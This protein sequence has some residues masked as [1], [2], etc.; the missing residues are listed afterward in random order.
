M[1]SVF[2]ALSSGVAVATPTNDQA[3]IIHLKLSDNEFG[4]EGET[5]ALYDVEDALEKAVTGAG[6]L[7]GHEIGKGFFTIYTYGPN[8]DAMLHAMLPVLTRGTIRSGSYV[9]VRRGPPG[10]D[11]QTLE[12]PI[13]VN[14]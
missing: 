13:K 2:A 4:A 9:I 6:E 8:A 14:Q 5:F 12:L 11:S 1:V 3:V 7:D 10:A